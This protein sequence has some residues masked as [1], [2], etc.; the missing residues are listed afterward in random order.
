[1]K[2]SFTKTIHLG[3][4]SSA[5]LLISWGCSDK[6][7]AVEEYDP[8]QPVELTDYYPTEGGVA[9]QMIL[10]GKNFGTDIS[11]INV[12]VNGF[13]ATVVS[14]NGEKI[15][16]ICP[17]KP[18]EGNEESQIIC[19]VEVEIGGKRLS[20]NTPFIYTIKTVVTTVCGT[21]GKMDDEV[22]TGTLAQTIIT[23]PT[24]LAIDADN[25]MI[26]SL[27][28]N[29]S[30][31]NNNKVIL[32]NEDE[33]QSRLLIPDTGAPLNQ[34]CMLDNGTTVYIPTDNGDDFWVMSSENMWSPMKQNLKPAQGQSSITIDFKHSFAMCTVDGY[35]YFRPKN[36]ILYKFDPAT[37]LTQLI[38]N[39]LMSS[40]DCYM[41]FSKKNPNML[42]MAYT[43]SNN[44]YS[45]DIKSKS[46]KLIA[47]SASGTPGYL[48]G[49]G[50][51][52]LFNEPRQ[53][54]LDENDDIY[55]ADTNNHC[56]RKVTPDGKV[57]T[58][59]GQGGESGYRDGDPEVALFNRPF[60]VCINND[61]IIY[62][63]DY[64]N[65]VIRRLAIE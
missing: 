29:N 45:Y 10:N 58:V 49:N 65:Y 7:E 63:A 51:T 55:I 5:L 44:I 38:D 23:H 39:N 37:N 40:S 30:Y 2:K 4:F 41:T 21:P 46:H 15:Y 18:G 19:D 53:L 50:N 42:Y 20:Y 62:V 33:D 3:V 52:A 56:I 27:R 8:S 36:G 12:Y 28:N 25:N 43:N 13:P 64:D 16:V 61:G 26:V 60:G 24:Y 17:R 22:T 9:T 14:S 35:M 6:K 11:K 31:Y 59:I 47:G 54:I 34:P 1:M 32:V 57:S 48:D